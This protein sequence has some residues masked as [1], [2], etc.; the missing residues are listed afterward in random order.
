MERRKFFLLAAASA[1]ALMT[2]AG[3]QPMG[4]PGP[5]HH[6]D[7]DDWRGRDAWHWRDDRGRWHGDHD[8]YWREGYGRRRYVDRDFIFGRLR[9]RGYRRFLGDPYW[10]HGRYVVRTYDRHGNVVI[11]EIDPYTGDF[12]GVIRF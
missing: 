4:G 9:R 8:R 11:A 2:G 5:R 10:Y 3:A 12:L 6:R 7:D 1:A